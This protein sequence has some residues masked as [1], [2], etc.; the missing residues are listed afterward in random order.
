MKSRRVLWSWLIVWTALSTG[1]EVT[2]EKLAVWKQSEN[3]APK[4]RAALRDGRQKLS[5]RVEAA[6]ALSE[7]GHFAPLAED[8]KAIPEPD[9]SKVML[10][11]TQRLVSRMKGTNPKAT[12][13]VQ[14]QAKDALFSIREFTGAEEKKRIDKEIVEWLIGDWANRSGGEHSSEKIVNALGAAAGAIL[15]EHIVDPGVPL[16]PIATHIRKLA[17]APSREL[18]A[19]KVVDWLRTAKPPLTEEILLAVARLDGPK[20]TAYLLE[21]VKVGELKTRLLVLHALAM[22][23]DV[24]AIPAMVAMASDTTLKDEAAQLRDDAFSVLEKIDDPQSLTALEGF[25]KSKEEQVRYRA[26]EA[27]IE[28]FKGKGVERLLEGLPPSFTY[29]KQDLE[30][31]IEKDIKGLQAA[32]LPPLRQGLESK[33]WIARLISARLLGDL[34]NAKDSEALDKLAGDPTK[35]KGWEGGA[36]IGSEAKVAAEKIRSRK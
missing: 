23:P 15:A 21:V 25:L 22:V 12:T 11:L 8:I 24:T 29:K 16:G 36:T 9:R 3:G 10:E 30:D 34:G 20:S 28:G 14:E 32:A 6:E 1:C 35:I 26:I 19:G 27:L 17:D 13:R 5:I 4:I 33:S 7:L 2:G 31:F 18:A